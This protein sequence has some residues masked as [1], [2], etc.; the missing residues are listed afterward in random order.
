MIGGRRAFVGH[1]GFDFAAEKLRIELECLFA[2][3]IEE[4]IGIHLRLHKTLL[5]YFVIEQPHCM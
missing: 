1:H 5:C 3:P 2:L 4:E